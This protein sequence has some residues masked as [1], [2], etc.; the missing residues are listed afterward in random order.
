MNKL[1]TIVAGAL[2]AVVGTSAFAAQCSTSQATFS[3]AAASDAV[4]IS[5][6]NDAGANGY[7]ASN[8]TVFGHDGWMMGEKND[9]P[10]TA[11]AIVNFST[12]PINGAKSGSFSISNPNS[13]RY[14]VALKAGN[15]FGF[16][17]MGMGEGGPFAWTST[18]DLSHATV[19]YLEGKTPPPDPVPLPAGGLLLVTALGAL[20]LRRRKS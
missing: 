3:I 17:D 18:K 4:C 10:G 2:F 6:D 5:K 16:F 8:P 7:F 1:M 13:L 12:D 20:A 9:E 15:G 11:N 19:W 14:G